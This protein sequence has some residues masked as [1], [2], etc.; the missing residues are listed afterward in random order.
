MSTPKTEQ[1]GVIIPLQ[2]GTNYVFDP[3]VQ[4]WC[5]ISFCGC[6]NSMK[7][8]GT[9]ELNVLTANGGRFPFYVCT[10]VASFIVETVNILLFTR[11]GTLSRHSRLVTESAA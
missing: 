6:S 7:R 11:P 4:F 5:Q 10:Y 2:F 1:F 3:S 8:G 9:S